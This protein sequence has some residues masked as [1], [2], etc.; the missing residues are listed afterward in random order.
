MGSPLQSHES[1]PREEERA[2]LPCM[3]RSRPRKH[4]MALEMRCTEGRE[5]MQL[6]GPVYAVTGNVS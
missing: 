4:S 2:M 6:G 1:E 3:A 5:F